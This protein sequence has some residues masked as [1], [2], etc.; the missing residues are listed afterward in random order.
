METVINSCGMISA[1]L[2]LVVMV[3]VAIA[4]IFVSKNDVDELND[5]HSD[6]NQ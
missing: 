6:E 2:A 1:I 3:G 4:S 5:P